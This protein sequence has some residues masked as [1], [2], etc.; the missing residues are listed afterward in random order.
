MDAA[1]ISMDNQCELGKRLHG[2]AMARCGR[3]AS[4]TECISKHA[5]MLDSD[6]PYTSASGAV[7]VAIIKLRK[8]VGL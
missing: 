4:H 3:L 1:T 5:A 6:T 7:G 8:E 2:E